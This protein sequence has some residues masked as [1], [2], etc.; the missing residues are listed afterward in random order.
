[1]RKGDACPRICPTRIWHLWRPTAVNYRVS[2]FLTKEGFYEMWNW[3]DDRTWYPLGRVIGGT[4]YPVSPDVSW[5]L[6]GTALP[7]AGQI[8]PFPLLLSQV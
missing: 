1:M 2:Q 5:V 8:A 3:F 4:V 7:Y 6:M